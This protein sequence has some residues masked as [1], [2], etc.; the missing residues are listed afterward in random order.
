M[1]HRRHL[2]RQLSV[3]ILML[4]VWKFAGTVLG[5]P[6]VH[7]SRIELKGATERIAELCHES[8][9]ADGPSDGETPFVVYV[10]GEPS[11]LF[12]LNQAGVTA[13]PVGDVNF[14][15]S[16]DRSGR[17]VPTFLVFGPNALRTP[18]FSYDWPDYMH[19][20][21]HLEDVE[22]NPSDVVLYNLYPPTWLATHRQQE[23]RMQLLEL[24][25]LK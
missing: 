11:V 19:R 16:T 20:F 21:Q 3:V 7:Q 13:A 24:Y 25:R 14:L 15:K 2:V 22:W 4:A 5:S 10:F 18:R 12:H 23:E 9:T 8:A 1:S 6:V 17:T